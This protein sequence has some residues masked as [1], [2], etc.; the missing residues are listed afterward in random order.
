MT[1]VGCLMLHCTVRVW[2]CVPPSHL[3]QRFDLS[4]P[5]FAGASAGA[6]TCALGARTLTLHALSPGYPPF[7]TGIILCRVSTAL[8]TSATSRLQLRRA[9]R[10]PFC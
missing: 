3:L 2:P 7:D 8:V 6:I 1:C 10:L 5:R 4:S 9:R